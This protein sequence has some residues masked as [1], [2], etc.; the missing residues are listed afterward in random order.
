[1]RPA[2]AR[3]YRV[4][5]LTPP[6]DLPE[7]LLASALARGWD[8][9]AV[10]MSYRPLGFG[11]HH[12]EVADTR[13]RRWF[14]TA[15]D[16][17]SKRLSLD[18]PL[19]AA[20]TRLR[21]ALRAARDLRDSGAAFV[22][23]PVA[24]ADGEP[25]LRVS[26]GFGVAV[27]PFVAGQSFQWGEF[28]APAHRSAVLGLVIAIHTA[29]AAARR[30]A[31]A[32]DFAIA[33]RDELESAVGLGE[34]AG[35]PPGRADRGPYARPA[36]ALLAGNAGPLRRLLARYDELAVA[37]RSRPGGMV[38]THGEPH[39]GNTMLTPGGWVLVDWDTALVA[40]PERDLWALDPGDGSVL[41]GY[42]AATGIA[43]APPMLELYRIRWDLADVAVT[44][45][46]FARP[47]D[48]SSDDDKS[49]DELRALV[50]RLAGAGADR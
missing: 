45:S 46:R 40:P 18:E 25:L 30:R 12:W 9:G 49:W 42:A 4:S 28:A 26:E 17:E 6:P 10:S 21:A 36:A 48:G 22:V 29:P 50:A 23:A 44:A 20:F 16:L 1:V 7:D 8:V 47:H 24:A 31:A 19:P 13:G 5:V 15:D 11:S 32:E 43:P 37:A 35:E 41:R 3:P 14:V 33:H 34:R 2:P 38:L 27:Y 39:P